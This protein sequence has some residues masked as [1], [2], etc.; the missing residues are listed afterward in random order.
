MVTAALKL[1][2]LRE[3]AAH[4][5]AWY[6]YQLDRRLLGTHPEV[7]DGLMAAVNELAGLGLID[8]RPNP[9]LGDIP[10]YWLTDAG[11][12]AVAEQR[13]AEPGAAPNSCP[14]GL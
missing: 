14:L 3:V 8:I 10:R 9:A 6:W 5:G 4:D 11:R 2:I 1:A 12:A 13:H 7:P